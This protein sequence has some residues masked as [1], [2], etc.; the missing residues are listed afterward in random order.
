M[1]LDNPLLYNE[2]FSKTQLWFFF[3][4]LAC[5]LNCFYSRQ[6]ITAY[7]TPLCWR[8][9]SLKNLAIYPCSVQ[10]QFRCAGNTNLSVSGCKK[11]IT[12]G[13]YVPFG[14]SC[15]HISF[16]N[17]HQKYGRTWNCWKHHSFPLR[18]NTTINLKFLKWWG[19]FIY[20]LIKRN[21]MQYL[22]RTL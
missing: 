10:M 9:G 4:T 22:R 6:H 15:I 14:W 21:S 7:F 18:K 13:D 5:T 3:F 1:T 11:N 16:P 20:I 17:S 12:L 8:L 19:I 2:L